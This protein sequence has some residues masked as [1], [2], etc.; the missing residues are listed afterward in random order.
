MEKE[1]IKADV[2]IFLGILKACGRVEYLEQGRL[3]HCRIIL[4]GLESD[5]S[6]GRTLIDMYAKCEGFLEAQHVFDKLD[7]KDIVSWN[8]LIASYLPRG[9]A[10][11]EVFES[12]QEQGILADKITYL[13]VLKACGNLGQVDKK[14]MRVKQ[15]TIEGC[16]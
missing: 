13:Y 2:I 10:S 9:Y 7:N 14:P 4:Y 8:S 5:I 6:L 1:G 11:I 3:M 12:M 16:D 15:Y